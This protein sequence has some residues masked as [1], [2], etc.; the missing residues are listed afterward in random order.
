MRPVKSIAAASIAA[1]LLLTCLAG[2]P[3]PALSQNSV[4][5]TTITETDCTSVKLGSTLPV[6]S[7]GEPVSSIVVKDPRW[8][9]ANGNAPAYCSVDGAM[10]PVDTATTAR[11]INFRVVFPFVWTRHAAQLGGGGFN[12]TIPNLTGNADGPLLARGFA[13]YGSDSGH[14]IAGPTDWTLNVRK[15]QSPTP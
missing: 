12:G 15:G 2:G 11:P 6:A 3:S 10:A 14:A 1:G 9:A 13:T 8:T 4:S 7:I 5:T